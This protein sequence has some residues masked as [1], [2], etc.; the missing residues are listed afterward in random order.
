MSQVPPV[1]LQ[2]AAELE[3]LNDQRANCRRSFI[4]FM[5]YRTQTLI[6][7]TLHLGFSDQSRF[8]Q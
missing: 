6:L 5:S 2:S 4:S 3:T 7:V 1:S 8:D